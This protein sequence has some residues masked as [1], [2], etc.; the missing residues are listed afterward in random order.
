MV[1]ADKPVLLSLWLSSPPSTSPRDRQLSLSSILSCLSRRRRCIPSNRLSITGIFGSRGQAVVLRVSAPAIREVRNLEH[2]TKPHRQSLTSDVLQKFSIIQ[3]LPSKLQL[4][5]ARWRPSGD[6]MAYWSVPGIPSFF[7]RTCELPRMSTCSRTE[8]CSTGLEAKKLAPSAAQATE[9][10]LDQPFTLTSRGGLST[11]REDVDWSLYIF[12]KDGN[13][14]TIG[15]KRPDRIVMG[16]ISNLVSSRPRP[17]M[18]SRAVKM[19][20]LRS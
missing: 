9:S 7:H 12:I 16:A 20:C 11:Q 5:M 2:L 13:A 14:G 15:R 17:F 18:G 10:K 19:S 1:N 3:M 6:G 8:P 4:L